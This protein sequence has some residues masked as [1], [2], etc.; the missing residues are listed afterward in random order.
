MIDRGLEDY[1]FFWKQTRIAQA[2]KIDQLPDII[3]ENLKSYHSNQIYYLDISYETL[4]KRKKR[5][6]S[7][8]RNFFEQYM[9]TYYAAEKIFYREIGA[10]FLTK[11]EI[12]HLDF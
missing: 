9:T 4:C 3:Y 11:H 12:K 6:T 1:I 7:R 2:L 5:D 8:S 10:T